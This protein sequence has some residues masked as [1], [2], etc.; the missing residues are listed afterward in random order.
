VITIQDLVNRIRWDADFGKADF[1][2]GYYDRIAD[3]IVYVSF[4]RISFEPHGH[5]SFTAIENDA[6]VHSVPFHRVREVW[7]DGELI[8][9]R[10]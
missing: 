3:R 2:I 5:F 10:A 1:V 6:S 9:H 7:R 4:E 8:W